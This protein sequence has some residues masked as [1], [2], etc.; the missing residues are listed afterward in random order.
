MLPQSIIHLE[1]SPYRHCHHL[2]TKWFMAGWMDVP[3]YW[4]CLQ[5][6]CWCFPRPQAAHLG[7]PACQILWAMSSLLCLHVSC[8][9]ARLFGRWLPAHTACSRQSASSVHQSTLL[10]GRPEQWRC[11]CG[12]CAVLAEVWVLC[13]SPRVA[14][15]P[16]AAAEGPLH[17][18]LAPLRSAVPR[19]PAVCGPA[20][21]PSSW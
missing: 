9:H 20:S 15:C 16:L 13:C 17:S 5:A 19:H 12:T 11:D 18:T 10:A 4:P 14:V 21:M 3:H 6:V 1:V 2:R 8:L 7:R